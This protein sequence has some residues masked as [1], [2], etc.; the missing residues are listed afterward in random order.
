MSRWSESADPTQRRDMLEALIRAV[1]RWGPAP[2]TE[3]HMLVELL[4]VHSAVLVDTREL[5]AH[6]LRCVSAAINNTLPPAH[7]TH[8]VKAVDAKAAT[9]P[10][11]QVRSTTINITPL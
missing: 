9:V 6:V 1:Q 7:W 11:D 8:V 2:S 10:F 3:H 4:G 5:C